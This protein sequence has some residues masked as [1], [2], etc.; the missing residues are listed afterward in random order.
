MGTTFTPVAG[1]LR[2]A[3]G[4]V[5]AVGEDHTLAW[6]ALMTEDEAGAAGLLVDGRASADQAKAWYSGNPAL[7]EVYHRLAG[8]P[9]EARALQHLRRAALDAA[10]GLGK[11]L[12]A[13]PESH[14]AWSVVELERGRLRAALRMAEAEAAASG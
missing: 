1:L 4:E 12:L 3:W 5:F 14:P 9:P 8:A 7:L 11:A 2:T 10:A 6:P 13:L